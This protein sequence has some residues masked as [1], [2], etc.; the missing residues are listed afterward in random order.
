M[1][2]NHQS[3]FRSHARSST[4]LSMHEH[5]VA[6]GLITREAK[7]GIAFL[8]PSSW[9]LGT[10]IWKLK[11][12]TCNKYHTKNIRVNRQYISQWET[13]QWTDSIYLNDKHTRENTLHT[14]LKNTNEQTLYIILK[15]TSEQ[16]LYTILKTTSEQTRHIILTNTLVNIHYIPHCET[17]Q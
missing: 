5:T 1:K 8:R 17:C 4:G 10:E 2:I 16:I 11:P 9:N 7:T 15:T 6:Y 13:Y 14:T 12:W 3:H